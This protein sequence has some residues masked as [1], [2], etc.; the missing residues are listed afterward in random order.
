MLKDVKV[1]GVCTTIDIHNYLPVT[2][3]NYF[4]GNNTE[5]VTS[6][7]ENSFLMSIANEKYIK[8]AQIL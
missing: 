5:I 2:T 7:K 6:G 4:K 3:I 1:S 8:K